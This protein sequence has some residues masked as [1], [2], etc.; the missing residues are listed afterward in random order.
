VD[1]EDYES[2]DEGPW[3]N[4]QN[5]EDLFRRDA[6]LDQQSLKVIDNLIGSLTPR[7]VKRRLITFK[8]QCQWNIPR[9]K[10]PKN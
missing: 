10:K 9:W 4:P 3:H 7:D 1:K 8:S 5:E 2:P 6:Y